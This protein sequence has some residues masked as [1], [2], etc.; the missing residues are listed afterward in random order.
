MSF[1]LDLQSYAIITDDDEGDDDDDDENVIEY[2][3]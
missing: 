3:S 2:L 1:L